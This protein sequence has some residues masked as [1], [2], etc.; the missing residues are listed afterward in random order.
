[1]GAFN[2]QRRTIMEVINS[3]SGTVPGLQV[4]G[5]NKE[6]HEGLCAKDASFLSDFNL[7]ER[8]NEESREV[9]NN[10]NADFRHNQTEFAHLREEIR[11]TA[12]HTDD[13]IQRLDRERLIGELQEVRQTNM[14][15]Q[16]RASGVVATAVT[17]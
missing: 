17:K 12:K 6:R 13:L 7:S 11:A 2:N 14:I 8:I 3:A 1:M 4:I 10:I 16:L 15:L 9:R 5:D